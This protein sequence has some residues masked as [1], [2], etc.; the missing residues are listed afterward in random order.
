MTELQNGTREETFLRRREWEKTHTAQG[1]PP[2]YNVEL[3]GILDHQSFVEGVECNTVGIY[4]SNESDFWAHLWETRTKSLLWQPRRRSLF[5]A[6]IRHHFTP[7]KFWILFIASMGVFGTIFFKMTFLSWYMGIVVFLV[8]V[9]VSFLG[10]L[11]YFVFK[12]IEHGDQLMQRLTSAC[13][14]DKLLYLEGLEKNLLK[15]VLLENWYT[16]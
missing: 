11:F 7:L 4:P 1:K 16:K 13:V 5:W 9:V 6:I 14:S 12:G 10:Y 3:R 8:F 2:E 15:V